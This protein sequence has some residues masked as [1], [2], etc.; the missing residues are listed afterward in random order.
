VLVYYRTIARLLNAFDHWN[1][2]IS[3]IPQLGLTRDGGHLTGRAASFV[4]VCRPVA[5]CP[6]VSHDG[7]DA[8]TSSL[9]TRYL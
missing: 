6:S 9:I 1:T 8:L 5:V 3:R 4:V 2:A 7:R